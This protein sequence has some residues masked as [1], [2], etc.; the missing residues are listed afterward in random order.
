[1]TLGE[2]VRYIRVQRGLT[3]Q[4]LG[5]MSKTHQQQIARIERGET[6]HPKNIDDI[7]KALNTS[8]L[9]LEYGFPDD[10]LNLASSISQLDDDKQEIIKSFIS[11]LLLSSKK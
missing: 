6:E 5:K 4:Q 9:L 11:N 3:Q 2:R 10:V 7:A 1:M 8:T